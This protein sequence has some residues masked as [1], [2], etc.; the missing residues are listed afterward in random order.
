MILRR[1][2]RRQKPIG[3]MKNVSSCPDDE[4]VLSEFLN[5]LQKPTANIFGNTALYRRIYDSLTDTQQKNL[6]DKI[7]NQILYAHPDIVAHTLRNLC[8]VSLDFGQKTEV[9]FR[10]KCLNR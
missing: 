9:S 5:Q 7:A 3:Y 6:I 4:T 10:Q 2:G 8:R 1:R